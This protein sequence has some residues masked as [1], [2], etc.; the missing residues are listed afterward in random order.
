MFIRGME[1][2]A[3]I[4]D[5]FEVLQTNQLFIGCLF[6]NIPLTLCSVMLNFKL[7]SILKAWLGYNFAI[8]LDPV[9]Q[10]QNLHILNFI[11]ILFLF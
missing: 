3:V 4:L 8:K 1:K 2:I 9:G 6:S 10:T 7:F 5:V 11:L